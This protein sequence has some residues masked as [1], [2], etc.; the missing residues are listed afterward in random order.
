M[1]HTYVLCKHICFPQPIVENWGKNR[2]SPG[3]TG[4]PGLFTCGKTCGKCGKAVSITTS[5][6]LHFLRYVNLIFCPHPTLLLR[7]VAVE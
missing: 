2:K 7:S 5:K 1:A 3:I 6:N 4:F